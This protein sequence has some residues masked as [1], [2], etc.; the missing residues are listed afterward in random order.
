[1]YLSCWTEYWCT[2]WTLLLRSLQ[3]DY[4]SQM[5]KESKRLSPRP[6]CPQVR[7][8]VLRSPSA[9]QIWRVEVRIFLFK[10]RQKPTIWD[11]LLKTS[12]W[13]NF[14]PWLAFSWR[15][16]M[17][18]NRL[19]ILKSTVSKRKS[20][21]GLGMKMKFNFFFIF[22]QLGKFCHLGGSSKIFLSEKILNQFFN[23]G[24]ISYFLL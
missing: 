19:N 21:S 22:K 10:V 8:L 12:S 4:P 3:K 9:K 11:N 14:S 6:F 16:R 20:I 24:Y 5:K 1:M 18:S 13:F 7:H 2:P 23:N 15:H 17:Y